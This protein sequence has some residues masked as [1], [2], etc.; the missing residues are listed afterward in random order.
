MKNIDIK[1]FVTS[2]V[3]LYDFSLSDNSHNC[4]SEELRTITHGNLC[5]YSKDFLD[6]L[7]CFRSRFE[8]GKPFILNDISRLESMVISKECTEF[9]DKEQLKTLVMAIA[10][11]KASYEDIC[12][13]IEE[14]DLSHL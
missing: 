11:I 8:E 12:R 14:Q 6:A 9:Y 1:R 4:I 3:E 13:F 10:C 5:R 2:F 7:V